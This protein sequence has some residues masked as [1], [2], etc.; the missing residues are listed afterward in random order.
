MCELFCSEDSP[1]EL[2]CSV[3]TH[4]RAKTLRIKKGKKGERKEGGQ[5]A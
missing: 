4:G 1:E 5:K 2:R 3:R